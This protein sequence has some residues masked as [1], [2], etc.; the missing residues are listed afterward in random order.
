MDDPY[1]DIRPGEKGTVDSVDDTGTIF[2]N[3][4]KGSTLGVVYGVDSIVRI[5]DTAFYIIVSDDG[6]W[7]NKCGWIENEN[8]AD[9]FTDK[10]VNRMHLPVGKNARWKKG[11]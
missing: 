5:P 6:F 10:E 1:A 11:N 7:T 3:W 2:V 4:D 9:I 8:D